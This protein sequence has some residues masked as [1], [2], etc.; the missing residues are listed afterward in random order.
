M[1]KISKALA[2]VSVIL[3]LAASMFTSCAGDDDSSDPNPVDYTALKTDIASAKQ[4][5][6]AAVIG[7]AIGNY[8]QEAVDTL[9][10]AIAT[11]QSVAD[12]TDAT[13]TQVDKARTDLVA[14]VNTFKASVITTDE[15]TVTFQTEGNSSTYADGVY[16]LNI[17]TA[18]EASVQWAN[19]IFISNP[20]K[21]AG[22]AAG[23]KVHATITVKS[24]KAI[25]KFFFKDQF[26]GAPSYSGID[27]GEGENIPGLEAGVAKTFDLYGVVAGDYNEAESKFVIDL[28]GNE[29][30][31]K[32][33]LSDVKVEKMTDYTVSAITVEVSS[34]SVSTGE[35]VTLTTKDQY[36][37]AVEGVTYTITSSGATSTL[38]G[39][40]LT[41]GTTAETVTLQATY[42]E[43]TD[44]TTITVTAEKDYGK[45][46]QVGKQYGDDPKSANDYMALWYVADT[47][48]N[49]G[50][51]VEISNVTA[52]ATEYSL[53]RTTTGDKDWSTQISYRTAP[54]KYAVSFKV[55]STAAGKI[56]VLPSANAS[57]KTVVD[58]AA[59]T[60]KEIK[61]IAE[62][63]TDNGKLMQVNLGA[64]ES[65][66]LPAGTFT[67][68]DFKVVDANTVTVS[69]VQVVPSA[70]SVVAGGKVNL[71]ATVNNEYAV[72]GA[73]FALT[74]GTGVTGSAIDSS[75]LT[76]GTGAGTVSVTATYEGKT[77]D[78][79][80]ITVTAAPTYDAPDLTGYYKKY[81]VT[82]D[83]TATKIDANADTWDC[84]ST[85]ERNTDGTYKLTSADAMWGG[86]GGC[87]LA[88]SGKE[89]SG[90][91]AGTLAKYD[92]VV[93]TLDVA[94]YEISS[95]DG[96]NDGINVKVPH[97][98][99]NNVGQLSIANNWVKNADGTR[100]YY[101]AL[102]DYSS[103]VSLATQVALI[104]GGK[105]TLVVKEFYI[106]AKNDPDAE[107]ATPVTFPYTVPSFTGKGD[108]GYTTIVKA[109]D[110]PS[111]ATAVTIVIDNTKC[112]GSGDWWFCYGDTA[113]IANV[114]WTDGVGY[115][116]EIT[117][118]NLAKIKAG[119]LGLIATDGLV[120]TN[121]ITVSVTEATPTP[122]GDELPLIPMGNNLAKIEGAGIWIYLDNTN[123]G[124]TGANA[125]EII[126]ASTVSIKDHDT[127]SA[128]TLSSWN[129]DDYGTNPSTVRLYAT[130]PDASHT[131]I[132]VD[133][134]LKIG[135][136]TYIGTAS[137]VSG[138]YQ[139]DYKPTDITLSASATEVKPGD[140][141]TFTVKGTPYDIDITDKCEFL[142]LLGDTTG[143]S[144]NGKTLTAG[145]TNGTLTVTA[146]YGE[147]SKNIN[148]T[149]SA[150]ALPTIM[151]TSKIE[152]AGVQIYISKDVVATTPAK[153]DITVSG[154]LETTEKDFQ[155][156]V[157]DNLTLNVVETNDQGTQ[158]RIYFTQP[159]GF[160]DGKAITETFVIKRDNVTV[161][162]VFEGN[163]LKS[164]SVVIAE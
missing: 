75:V 36:G 28:R 69:S 42:G 138:V 122:A 25:T 137:F 160:P 116:A 98:N 90:F 33:E 32:L 106:A 135:T 118:D 127:G 71:S 148:I 157:S 153:E 53:T 15:L 76:V 58:L 29:A 132:D 136:K 77:S 144:I 16:T 81:F 12:K 155:S 73:T 72:S 112:A 59:D 161:N 62:V 100:T 57:I 146:S 162:A 152:G 61:F 154:K 2:L 47:S 43:L 35:N 94:S 142:I 67:L 20:N 102:A 143:S 44:T 120:C 63:A 7:T 129:F 39:N 49:C 156:Y 113:W 68:S 101:A 9:N 111:D 34:A 114:V 133:I 45:Y 60:E 99:D 37:F 50:P 27:V 86:V 54:G 3:L 5:A 79:V 96:N 6:N 150:A 92:Y 93:L 17:G 24:D 140:T 41:A 103:T 117:G 70:T 109:S 64:S 110:I 126:E 18:T 46:F 131:T 85:A 82:A 119:G 124:I 78:A 23:D 121:A 22:V 48:W 4:L 11:A 13:Q 141:V 95:G 1:K 87:V 134:S 107:P 158:S 164:S 30:G 10:A 91:V 163:A 88:F 40:T 159:A 14:A 31:T 97:P 105:G 139:F 38:T 128:V 8:P 55:K 56:A 145:S 149:V 115:K 108:N 21:K 66:I 147:L 80:E 123:L 83:T 52:S 89:G 26:N 104:A 65:E 84:G 74:D 125:A 130:M 151:S 19:Q 51:V